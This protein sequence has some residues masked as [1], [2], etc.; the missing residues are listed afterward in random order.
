M[1]GIAYVCMHEQ[2]AVRSA[3]RTTSGTGFILLVIMYIY[4]WSIYIIIYN[5]YIF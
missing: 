1:H 5:L 2:A 4:S 3:R